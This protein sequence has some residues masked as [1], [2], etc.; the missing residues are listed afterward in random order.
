MIEISGQKKV[1]ASRDKLLRSPQFFAL[2]TARLYGVAI[3]PSSG[4]LVGI[5]TTQ[6][7]ERE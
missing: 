5:K 3:A 4:A 6:A 2:V 7:E 1:I